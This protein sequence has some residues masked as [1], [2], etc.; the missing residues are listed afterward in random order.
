MGAAKDG[1]DMDT[2]SDGVAV[3]LAGDLVEGFAAGVG[4]ADDADDEGDGEEGDHAEGGYGEAFAVF[5]ID[6]GEDETPD[7]GEATDD[8]EHQTLGT[9]TELGR[10][11]L[12]PPESIEYLRRT[13][14]LDAPKDSEK[15]EAGRP[16]DTDGDDDYPCA[17]GYKEPEDVDSLVLDFVDEL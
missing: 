6:D 4:A 9:S 13:A 14:A 7:S 5:T 3:A 11:K 15:P 16:I 2:I 8:E 10:E 1:C 17:D 12:R